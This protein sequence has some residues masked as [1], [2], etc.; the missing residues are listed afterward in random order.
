M[1]ELRTPPAL[2]FGSGLT[3]LGVIRIL[4]RRGIRS[5]VADGRVGGV[6]WSR[7]F[8]TAPPG[9]PDRPSTGDLATYLHALDLRAAVLVGCS[10]DWVQCIAAQD[11]S[12]RARF[13]ASLP[14]ARV[15]ASLVDKRGL[16]AALQ[17]AG[18]PHPETRVLCS[19][20]DLEA[21]PE[22]VLIHSFLKP[23]QSQRF[24]PVFEAKAFG[25][26][27]K[28]DALAKFRRTMAAGIPMLLQE[29]VPGPPSNHYF[30]D[31]FLDAGGT[32]RA[33]F[34]RRRYRMYPH[35]FGNSSYMASVPVSEV[36]EAATGI[37]QLLRHVGYRGVFSAEFKRDQRDGVFKLLE[38]NVRPWWYVE[39][40]A[41]CGVDVCYMYY[42][43]ALQQPVPSAP[44][45]RTGQRLV[46]T[47]CDFKAWTAAR[48]G[49]K[50]GFWNH[51]GAW[52]GSHRATFAW[53]DPV[54]AVA[55][56]LRAVTRK[57]APLFGR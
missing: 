53:D 7:W 42:L 25:V 39:F 52:I 32:F 49:G 24:G 18:V 19:E 13:H 45:Y 12:V 15:I 22:E 2:V 26:A 37:R 29:Y 44:Q 9:A 56:T 47:W 8:R 51:W 40:A 50:T 14:D 38:V 30:I 16:A 6:R 21:V 28:P 41:R 31:G 34:A 43:D 5:L 48:A 17:A 54:P 35:D 36:E 11:A 20:A 1:T 33:V 23:A 57:I 3:A 27:S 55:M 46:H 4:G 10:D